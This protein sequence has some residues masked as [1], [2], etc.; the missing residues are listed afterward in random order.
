[1]SAFYVC[2]TYD[3]YN[4]NLGA[5]YP[6]NDCI[7][8]DEEILGPWHGVRHQTKEDCYNNSICNKSFSS[9]GFAGTFIPP[10]TDPGANNY[11]NIFISNVE[12]ISQ[13]N[14]YIKVKIE[15]PQEY[16][17]TYIEYI[18][19][20]FNNDLAR[21][22]T[23]LC[24]KNLL[25]SDTYTINLGT[26]ADGCPDSICLSGWE[27][28]GT[29]N[30]GEQNLFD[31]QNINGIYT[32]VGI[33]ENGNPMYKSNN[34]GIWQ[35]DNINY[36]PGQYIYV[37]DT[38][39]A[40]DQNLDYVDEWRIELTS[41]PFFFA[42]EPWPLVWGL[43]VGESS[44]NYIN[45]SLLAYG[46]EG[47][48]CPT[49]IDTSSMTIRLGNP[50]TVRPQIT[51]IG[52]IDYCGSGSGSEIN[53]ICNI[54]FR[55]VRPCLESS[56]SGSGSES[57]NTTQ[58]ILF[59]RSSWDQGQIDPNIAALLSAAATAWEE[60]ISFDPAIISALMED[61][62]EWKGIVLDT[63]TVDN[64][65][66]GF[67]A[68]C[69]P[70]SSIQIGSKNGVAQLNSLS[71]DLNINTYYYPSHPNY[72][73]NWVRTMMHELGHA[74]GIGVFWYGGITNN[75]W[76][77]GTIYNITQQAYND[78]SGMQR[79]KTPLEDSGSVPGTIG[80][81]WENNYRPAGYEIG[82]P[83]YSG[84]T[85][86]MIGMYSLWNITSISTSFLLDLG[87]VENNPNFN[88]FSLN[89][90]NNEIISDLKCGCSNPNMKCKKTITTKVLNTTTGKIE[91]S[92]E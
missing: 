71:F 86:I 10:T 59:D 52:T 2:T 8:W 90:L 36:D 35:Y 54:G 63:L 6:V 46:T 18:L 13:T 72:S 12:L 64:F 75:H 62:P 3:K 55:L 27:A 21:D 26:A 5:F 82:E 77:D 60:Y 74:L 67:L 45:L 25:I 48:C 57:G 51:K 40:I 33:S 1:M 9:L 15:L 78:I 24:R 38:N 87:Y 11:C 44:E 34:Y 39:T 53:N 42:P 28:K 81:H 73:I 20:D 37:P 43:R 66:E 49:D 76:L 30:A 58:I 88:T 29:T 92:N 7:L 16:K 23:R 19:Y 56:E 83:D 89:S 32:K 70:T 22:W 79:I 65:G 61:N 17:N 85:D 80:S 31:F 84:I 50:G 41:E 69:G 47:E 91:A 4:P 68:S 14:S